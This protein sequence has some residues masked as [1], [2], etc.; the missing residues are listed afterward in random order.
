[1]KVLLPVDGSEFSQATLDWAVRF[2]DKETEYY[3]LTVISDTMVAEYKLEDAT[4]V[5]DGAKAYL[6]KQGGRVVKSEYLTG[7]PVKRICQAADD[8]EVDQVLV[9]SHGRSG[10]AKVLLG[11]V[12]EGVLAHCRK[13]VFIYRQRQDQMAGNRM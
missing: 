7:D 2:L 10:I 1:M 5:L 3:L 12:S 6:E 13:P 4:Q 8:L 11:S 9:G